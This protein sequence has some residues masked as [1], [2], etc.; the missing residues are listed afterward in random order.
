MPAGR[1][2]TPRRLG[3]H[4]LSLVRHAILSSALLLAALPARADIT[5]GII[6]SATGPAAALGIPQRNTVELVPTEIG[7][8]HI[9]T[10]VID[11]A[12]DSTAAVRAAHKLIDED[13][14]DVILGPS[15]SANSL[16]V[17]EFAGPAGTPIVTLAGCAA[18]VEPQDGPR[19][20]AFKLT[21]NDR[22]IMDV[23][24]AHMARAGVTK[25]ADF[26]F[27]NAFGDAFSAAMDSSA[28]RRGIDPVIT[29][30]YSPAD[31]SVGPQA[32]RLMATKPDAV[33]IAGSGSP[34]ITPILDLRRRGYTGAIYG[35]PGAASRDVLRLGGT[36]VEGLIL[37]ASPFFVAEQLPDTDPVKPVALDYDHAYEARF[38]E[39]TRSQ[40]GATMW[41]AFILLA[42]AVPPALT[43]G[44]PGTAEFRTGLR[45]AMEHASFTGAEG[46][47]AMTAAD[48][49]GSGESLLVLVEV[50]DGAWRLIK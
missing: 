41:D 44:Q 11:D 37:S 19:R 28:K 20:W 12:S 35:N 46:P 45:D 22:P 43:A 16:A 26:A 1:A 33:F 50:K 15:N 13:H 31:T 38:G 29:V 8:Q 34:A 27:S 40:T 10:I 48:H 2:R 18:C 47:Y 49:S 6:V 42:K 3:A 25:L 36:A 32:L 17:I 39:A 7:G 9:R 14:V 21:P 4:P 30:R 23:L 24:T 5:V